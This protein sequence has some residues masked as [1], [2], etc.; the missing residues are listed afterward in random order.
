MK[1]KQLVQKLGPKL[2]G[3]KINTQPWGDYPGG[4]A[5]VVTLE[6]DKSA[7]EIVLQVNLPQYGD[8][9]VF[10]HEEVSVIRDGLGVIRLNQNWRN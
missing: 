2:I 8:M 9:G 4:I 3:Q 7:P 5:T 6:P 1:A 10:S